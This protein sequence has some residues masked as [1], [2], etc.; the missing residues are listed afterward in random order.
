MQQ[1]QRQTIAQRQADE[2]QRLMGRNT[3][4]VPYTQGGNIEV[5]GVQTKY[6]H[7]QQP[8]L[9][10]PEATPLSMLG[11][12]VSAETDLLGSYRKL[13]CDARTKYMPRAS[14]DLY[15]LTPLTGPRVGDT[16]LFDQ[17]VLSGPPSTNALAK[18]SVLLFNNN[19]RAQ[20]KDKN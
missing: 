15:M 13:S 6:T 18:T 1:Q 19:T 16:L 7:F 20:V 11:F 8:E 3:P 4:Y 5:Y 10:K 9:K 14:S 12:N 17:P 2:N